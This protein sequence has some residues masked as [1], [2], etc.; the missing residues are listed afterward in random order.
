M[1]CQYKF[2]YKNK[3]DKAVL[4]KNIEVFIIFVCNLISK[5]FINLAKKA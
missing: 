2:I 5:L 1:I 4:D 3:F